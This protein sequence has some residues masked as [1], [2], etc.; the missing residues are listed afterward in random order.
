LERYGSQK[1]GVST[2][3][4]NNLR[5]S[6]NNGDGADESSDDDSIGYDSADEADDNY[7]VPGRFTLKHQSEAFMEVARA[8]KR[9][10]APS[11]G[12]P[13]NQLRGG[14][15]SSPQQPRGA[16]PGRGT[17]PRLPSSSK[18]REPASRPWQ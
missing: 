3:E 18:P 7:M 1:Q 4:F 11:R 10:P 16:L 15:G 6:Y 14:R 12:S 13:S 2:E 17:P 5:I 9:S 8:E